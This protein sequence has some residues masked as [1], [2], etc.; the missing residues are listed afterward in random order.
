[1]TESFA[2]AVERVSADGKNGLRL[3]FP[4]QSQLA[5]SRC[6]L[7]EHKTALQQAVDQVAGMA[8]VMSFDLASPKVVAK[9]QETSAPRPSRMQRMREIEA[10]GLIQSCVEVF[11]AEIVRIDKPK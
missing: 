4:A 11:G 2:R 5:K 1:M 6:E 3:V 10:N 7:P 9:K 8:I